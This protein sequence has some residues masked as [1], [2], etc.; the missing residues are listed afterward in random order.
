MLKLSIIFGRAVFLMGITTSLFAQQNDLIHPC[1]IPETQEHGPIGFGVMLP[2]S[3]E[4]HALNFP[5]IYY[6]HGLNQNYLSERAKWIASFFHTQMTGGKLPECILVFPDG[7]DGFWCDHRDGNPLLETEAVNYLI[8][9]LDSNYNTDHSKRLL[10]GFSAGGVGAVLFYVK[11]PGIFSAA[12][13]LDGALMNWEDFLSFQGE[14]PD[15]FGSADY[16]YEYGS[17]NLW[18]E[19]NRRLLIEKS[20]TSIF[21]SAA[22]L[23]KANKEF[24]S[25]LEEQGIPAR[26]VE[27]DCGHEFGCIFSKSQQELM[28]FLTNILDQDE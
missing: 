23:R 27:V 9:F 2:P 22:F 3:Y 24:L 20:D 25:I 18:V 17:P 12:V 7:V 28:R 8:P 16:Y 15:I 10:M 26:Y 19:R 11:H 14:K 13:S 6:L 1:V 21:L 5:V 4:N